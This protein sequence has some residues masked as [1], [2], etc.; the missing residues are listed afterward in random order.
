MDWLTLLGNK[1]D[2]IPPD[3]PHCG[4]ETLFS[5]GE[6]HGEENPLTVVAIDG[7]WEAR[8]GDDRSIQTIFLHPQHGATLPFP[9]HTSQFRSDVRA[10]LGEPTRSGE[11]GM[12]P[13]LGT[14]R[15]WDRYDSEAA[16]I[17]IE[18]LD[19]G[20]ISML[21]LMTPTAVP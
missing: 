10:A 4:I 3:L 12:I 14:S 11:G 21:T 19:D 18:Y 16:S 20:S 17:H 9:L 15:R 1:A 13:V 7:S 2:S 8:L 6:A 5:P